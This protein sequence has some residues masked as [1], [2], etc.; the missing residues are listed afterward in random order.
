MMNKI[1]RRIDRSNRRPFVRWELFPDLY[2]TRRYPI[3]R[4]CRYW[5]SP[6]HD[7]YRFP[8]RKSTKFLLLCRF[9][10]ESRICRSLPT[11]SDWSG[12]RSATGPA[13]PKHW[14]STRAER[15][16][17][18]CKE[19]ESLYQAAFWF[20]LETDIPWFLL[21]QLSYHSA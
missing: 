2:V 15:S 16:P 3:W 10:D 8:Y 17:Y 21:F 14:K 20:P 13:H 1:R 12:P 6:H 7:S 11:A 19:N 9:Q 18:W 4:S 5:P